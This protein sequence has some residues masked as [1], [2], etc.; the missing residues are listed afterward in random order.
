MHARLPL[1]FARSAAFAAVGVALAALAHTLAG[2][3][4]PAPGVFGLGFAGVL[5]LGLVLSGRE[6][7]PATIN[8]TLVGAQLALHYAFGATPAPAGGHEQGLGQDLGMLLAHLV[9]TLITGWW[10]ARGE[11]ALWSLL[12][13]VGRRFVPLTPVAVPS[14]RRAPHFYQRTVPICPAVSLTVSRRGPPLPA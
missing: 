1:R 6:R 11:S 8:V 7:S 12:R 13:G 9:A 2:G 14:V 10:L 5:V 4:G 3:S